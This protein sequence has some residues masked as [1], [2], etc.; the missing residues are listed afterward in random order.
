MKIAVLGWGSLLWEPGAEFEKSIELP[1]K[2]DGP[3]LPIEF[4]RISVSRDGALTLAIDETN[5][6]LTKVAWCLSTREQIED[7]ISDLREREGTTTANIAHVSAADQSS[8]LASPLKE[9]LQWATCRKIDAVLWTALRSNFAEQR[10]KPFSVEEAIAYL[11]GLDEI[12]KGR[13]AEYVRNAPAFVRTKLRSALE[14]EL[15]FAKPPTSYGALKPKTRRIIGLDLETLFSPR[16]M[17]AGDI[18]TIKKLGKLALFRTLKYKDRTFFLSDEGAAALRRVTNL[19]FEIPALAETVSLSE[20]A[21]EVKRS[22]EDWLERHLVPDGEEFAEPITNS[23]LAKVKDYHFLVRLQGLDLMDQNALKVGAVRVQK[24][25][26]TLLESAKF[27]GLLDK[28]HIAKQFEGSLWLVGSSEGSPDVARSRFELQALLT[29][30]ILAICGAVLYDGAIWRSCVEAMLSSTADP[31]AAPLLMWEHGG[32]HISFSRGKGRPQDLPLNAN[33][34]NYLTKECFLPHMAALIS[35]KDRTDLE[36]AIVRALYWMADAHRDRNP[37]MQFVKLWT[38][39]ECFFAIT[40]EKITEANA[41]GVAAILVYG[42][43]RVIE[44]SRYTETKRRV[45]QLY[46][47]RSRALHRAQFGHVE[48]SDL[49][50]LSSWVAWIIITM[51]AFSKG[52]CKTLQ[53]VQEQVQRLDKMS[54]APAA[55]G[56]LSTNPDTG[57]S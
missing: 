13:A 46:K 16:A 54:V 28:D 17:L 27:G 2:T 8:Q 53:Q 25:D 45:K 38:C 33:A 30:G 44:T 4:S 15:G 5:G 34:V 6:T 50:E 55:L 37:M 41:K 3:A 57:A 48:A 32:D 9:I 40:D 36:D 35:M 31:K 11:K 26:R 7:A 24:A 39:V 23:L 20:V 29:T 12:G 21:A 10:G 42:G 19:I 51:V 14:N 18:E 56:A 47:L 1:W 43:Y 52:G 22:Y 49:N